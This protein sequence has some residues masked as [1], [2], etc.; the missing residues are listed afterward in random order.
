MISR[1]ALEIATATLTGTFGVAVAVSSLDLGVAWTTSGVSPGTLPFCTGLVII[2]GSLFNLVS[3]VRMVH[4]ETAIDAAN[5]R[6]LA[7]LFVPAA[8]Y[9]AAIPLLGMYVSSALYVFGVLHVQYRSPLL[10]GLVTAAVVVAA[11]YCLF[12]VT[13]RVYLP[14]GWL[15]N[16][17]G[18]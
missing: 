1:R 13:F 14:R 15:G 11:L 3:G 12:E 10:R 8:A 9:I 2:G 4:G 7:G 16:A 5:G 18:F 17:L 6:R